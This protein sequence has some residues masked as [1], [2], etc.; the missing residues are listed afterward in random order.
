MA[1]A[2]EEEMLYYDILA[3]YHGL[4]SVE[5]NNGVLLSCGEIIKQFQAPID[6]EKREADMKKGY[7]KYFK[8]CVEKEICK[9]GVLKYG[10]Y[11]IYV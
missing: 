7:Q 9:N 8:N 10:R 6:Y 2:L 4:Y 5:I 11:K 1:K 3:L